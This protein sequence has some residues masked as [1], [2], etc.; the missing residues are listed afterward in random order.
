M[1]VVY[2]GAVAGTLLLVTEHVRQDCCVLTVGMTV[3]TVVGHRALQTWWCGFAGMGVKMRPSRVLFPVAVCLTVLLRVCAAVPVGPGRCRLLNRNT[4]K[5]NRGG[6][7]SAV[8]RAVMRLAP[9]WAIHMGTQVRRERALVPAAGHLPY[10]T[11]HAPNRGEQL[12]TVLVGVECLTVCA[13][14]QPCSLRHVR[15]VCAARLHPRLYHCA[16]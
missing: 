13:A 5:F 10:V 11:L 7:G 14:W 12:L 16:A 9:D 2:A 4:F 8:A 15:A 6:I 1:V 3:R